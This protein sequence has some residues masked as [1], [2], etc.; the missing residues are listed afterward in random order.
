LGRWLR[1]LDWP[2]AIMHERPGVS[3]TVRLNVR[4]FFGVV[5]VVVY[6][7][8]DARNELEAVTTIADHIEGA[9]VAEL[10]ALLNGSDEK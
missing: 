1:L 6:T 9:P 3:R 8:F 10:L 7:T 5:P 4:G 2:G